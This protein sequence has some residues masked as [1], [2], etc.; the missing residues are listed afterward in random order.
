MYNV[1]V[2]S[3]SFFTALLQATAALMGLSIIF[4]I[5]RLQ[6]EYNVYQPYVSKLLTDSNKAIRDDCH[7]IICIGTS[8]KDMAESINWLVE[9]KGGIV[10]HDGKNL[11]GLAL[12]IAGLM[13]TGNVK[14][15]AGKYKEL[16]S[17]ARKIGS[18][19]Q[20]PFMTLSFMALLVIPE[21][22]M[23]DMGLFSGKSFS[24]VSKFFDQD[25]Q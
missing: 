8:D 9:N 11:F 7:N 3:I 18:E 19:M 17:I 22:K 5:Y 23:S 2:M 6:H 4:V 15:A 13:T 25:E 10:V 12:E 14:S 1:Y 20:A 21:L 16:T 24:F